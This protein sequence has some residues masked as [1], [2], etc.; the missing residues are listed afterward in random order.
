M[1]LEKHAKQ[2]TKVNFFSYRELFIEI[3]Y[4]CK[5]AN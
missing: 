1:K 4:N 3:L 2:D 5:F